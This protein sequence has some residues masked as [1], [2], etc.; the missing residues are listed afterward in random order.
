MYWKNCMDASGFTQNRTEVL[1]P[2][3]DLQVG[4]PEA[5]LGTPQR[6]AQ[7]FHPSPYV[8]APISVVKLTSDTNTTLTR[9]FPRASVYLTVLS[10]AQKGRK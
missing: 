8:A 3:G 2:K 1:G 5:S 7:F 9:W 4:T 10:S 6:Q